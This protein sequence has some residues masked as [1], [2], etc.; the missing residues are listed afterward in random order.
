MP[1]VV[2]ITTA[3]AG[4]T[5]RDLEGCEQL[6]FPWVFPYSQK[7]D[8]KKMYLKGHLKRTHSEWMIWNRHRHKSISHWS[9]GEWEGLAPSSQDWR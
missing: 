3:A 5:S 9:K 1:I 2:T 4:G 7:V 6:L 8:F